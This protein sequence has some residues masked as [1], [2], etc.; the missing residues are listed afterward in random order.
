M[1]TTDTFQDLSSEC[2]PVSSY[3]IT[4]IKTNSSSVR[5][6][7]ILTC[8]YQGSGGGICRKHGILKVKY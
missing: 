5:G 8:S 1:A 4:K 3:I 2:V 6:T 7:S